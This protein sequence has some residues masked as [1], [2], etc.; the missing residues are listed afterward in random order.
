MLKRSASQRKLISRGEGGWGGPARHWPWV[1]W[2]AT[3]GRQSREHSQTAGAQPR[4]K[5]KHRQRNRPG[6][7]EAA[8]C[9]TMASEAVRLHGTRRQGNNKAGTSAAARAQAGW[10][11]NKDRRA[12]QARAD[13]KKKVKIDA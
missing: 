4:G 8:P 6:E 13:A 10:P 7:A 2:Q 1:S 5:N 9:P 11:R 12:R 3:L